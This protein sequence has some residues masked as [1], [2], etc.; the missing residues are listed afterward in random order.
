MPELPEVETIARELHELLVG[1]T[2]TAVEVCWPRTI[3]TPSPTQFERQ[4]VGQTV[5]AVDRRGKFL[6]LQLSEGTTLLVHLRMSGQLLW[7]SAASPSEKH[8]RVVFT[9]DDGSTLRFRD[10]R[11]FGRMWLVDDPQVVLGRLGPEPLVDDFTPD[12]LARRLARHSGMLK[13]LLLNQG[14]LAGLGNI[15]ADEVLFRAGLHPQRKAN[16][17]NEDEVVRLYRAIRQVLEEAITGQGTTFDGVY[18]QVNGASGG[19]QDSLQVY[20]R[21]GEPCPRCG[22]PIERVTVGGRSTH[23]CPHCQPAP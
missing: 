11:K 13:P 21:T 9:L 12:A 15:Y 10:Q 3:A 19:F 2:I 22:K 17:L 6:V 23:F 7:E 8:L 5:Q 1:R 14:F 4:I 20:G 18:Q 16:S